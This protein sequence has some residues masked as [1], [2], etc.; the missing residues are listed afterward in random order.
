MWILKA[1]AATSFRFLIYFQDKLAILKLVS[2]WRGAP[3]DEIAIVDY[4]E[5]STQVSF[6]R[7]IN[8]ELIS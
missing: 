8:R 6:T 7:A 4:A 2:I 1:I 5:A 3:N